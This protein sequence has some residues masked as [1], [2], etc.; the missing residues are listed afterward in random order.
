MILNSPL[1]VFSKISTVLAK[2]DRSYDE[3]YHKTYGLHVLALQKPFI[4]SE[5]QSP[6]FI[7]SRALALA[8][9]EP[10]GAWTVEGRN[11]G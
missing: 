7:S 6:G 8:K 9:A 5:R 10:R 1:V 2:F 4:E 3:L 11:R